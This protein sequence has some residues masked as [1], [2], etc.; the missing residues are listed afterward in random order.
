[1]LKIQ[2]P[3]LLK[4]IPAFIESMK[5]LIERYKEALELGV[6]KHDVENAKGQNCLLCHPIDLEESRE[7]I[8][9]EM[10]NGES[11]NE[12]CKALGCPWMVIEDMTCDQYSNTVLNGNT[13]YHATEPQV[14]K[15]RIAQLEEWIELYMAEEQKRKFEELQRVTGMKRPDLLKFSKE[16]VDSMHELIRHYEEAK[17]Q[18]ISKSE[19]EVANRLSCLLCNPIGISDPGGCVTGGCPWHVVLDHTCLS[20]YKSRDHEVIDARITQLKEWIVLYVT[21]PEPVNG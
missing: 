20:V 5:E 2:N 16:Y 10:R 1:M 15:N 21:V 11:P 3:E 4:H 14:I 18:G 6:S 13:V 12:A 19:Y 7:S 9:F 8:Y 17:K